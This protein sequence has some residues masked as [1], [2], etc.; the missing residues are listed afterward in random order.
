MLLIIYRQVLQCYCQSRAVIF[1]IVTASA[2]F[3]LQTCFCFLNVL[4][5]SYPTSSFCSK[6][7]QQNLTFITVCNGLIK[8]RW[9]FVFWTAFFLYSLTTL[10]KIAANP[11]RSWSFW[12]SDFAF[13]GTLINQTHAL[14]NK[15]GQKKPHDMFL[16][17]RLELS[18]IVAFFPQHLLNAFFVCFSFYKSSLNM[19]LLLHVSIRSLDLPTQLFSSRFLLSKWVVHINQHTH[20][21]LLQKETQNICLKMWVCLGK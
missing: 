14:K 12:N 18:K 7:L 5:L 19:P 11:S 10:T 15:H 21:S 16:R 3:H 8:K 20:L 13:R 17:Q 2:Y 9:S 1:C 6:K 4:D